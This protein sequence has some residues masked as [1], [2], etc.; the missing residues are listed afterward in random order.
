MNLTDVG[1]V[2]RIRGVA[3]STRVSFQFDNS[4]IHSARGIFN[5]FIPDVYIF[6]DHKK[7]PAAGKYVSF[8][9]LFLI[10]I[11]LRWYYLFK[12]PSGLFG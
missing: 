1:M 9:F 2:K 11:I 12:F 4:M 7:G 5:R 6:S 8:S 3:Y 10:I